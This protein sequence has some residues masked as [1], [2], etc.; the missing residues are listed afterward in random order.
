VQHE[1][2]ESRLQVSALNEEKRRGEERR[3]EERRGEKKELLTKISVGDFIAGLV[4]SEK[5]RTS[6][7]GPATL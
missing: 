6:E 4:V 5:M 1:K 3:G 2:C 7:G